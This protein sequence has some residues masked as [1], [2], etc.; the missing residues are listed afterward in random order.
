M[1]TLAADLKKS[2]LLSEL[3]EELIRDVIIPNGQLRDLA[4]GKVIVYPYDELDS[5]GFVL[6]GKLQVQHYFTAGQRTI[7]SALEPP[8]VVGLDVAGSSSRRV[9]Y[10]VIAAQPSRVF[11]LPFSVLLLE[12]NAVKPWREEILRALLAALSSINMRKEYHLAV[13]SRSGLR[14]RIWVYLMMQ[15]E[16]QQSATIQI[17]FTQEEMASFLCVNRTVLSH[18]LNLMRKEGLID[19]KRKS[20]TIIAPEVE[21]Q[22]AF[23]NFSQH[24]SSPLKQAD[25]G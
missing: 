20:F 11:F 6:Y 15:V 2:I 8:E 22:N 4:Q 21:L 9:P 25:P 23:Y 1:D 14:E 17:P 16:R 24:K 13:L 7:M 12:E 10:H 3:P 5:F 19:Y 18:E